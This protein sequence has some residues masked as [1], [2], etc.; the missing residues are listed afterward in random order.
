MTVIPEEVAVTTL[1]GGS[2]GRARS[3]RDSLGT[4]PWL[5]IWRLV[6]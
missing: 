2:R 1:R 4:Q 3:V 6:G 5:E